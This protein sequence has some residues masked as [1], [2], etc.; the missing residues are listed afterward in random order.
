[1]TILFQ[2]KPVDQ[3]IA[4]VQRLETQIVSSFQNVADVRL[5][6]V[7]KFCRGRHD[8]RAAVCD[9]RVQRRSATIVELN[10]IGLASTFDWLSKY[11][12][13]ESMVRG[14]NGLQVN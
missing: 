5:R 1:M 2:A 4:E 6:G 12:Q 8:E 3:R 10:G 14:S 7:L 9:Q 11:V 13:S